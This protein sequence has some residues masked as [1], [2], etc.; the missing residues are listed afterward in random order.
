MGQVR[1]SSKRLAVHM[2]KCCV[3]GFVVS[4][5]TAVASVLVQGAEALLLALM[6]IN[7]PVVHAV[8]ANVIAL[9]YVNPSPNG[10]DISYNTTLPA[11]PASTSTGRR[12]LEA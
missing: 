5:A 6:Q 9:F 11:C 12:L 7:K 4:A 2:F 10:T 1:F 8:P 3:A